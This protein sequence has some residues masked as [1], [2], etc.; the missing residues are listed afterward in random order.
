MEE[1][2]EE[3]K[4][5]K[6]WERMGKKERDKDGGIAEATALASTG[7]KVKDKEKVKERVEVIREKALFQTLAS[8]EKQKLYV[9][10]REPGFW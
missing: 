6:K 2:W 3:E 4:G 10:P 8:S 9:T 7:I 5:R 1:V